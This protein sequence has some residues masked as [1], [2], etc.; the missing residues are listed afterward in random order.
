MEQILYFV[1]NVAQNKAFL[2]HMQ[3]KTRA[4]TCSCTNAMTIQQ[5]KHLIG[6]Q[7]NPF[8]PLQNLSPQGS[9]K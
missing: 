8:P 3:G 4:A 5:L 6:S 1:M 9:P 7:D 2:L